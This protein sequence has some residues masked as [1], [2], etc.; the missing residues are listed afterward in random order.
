MT[1]K[2]SISGRPAFTPRT[3]TSTAFGE[4][5]AEFRQAP[6][7]LEIDVEMRKQDAA[8]HAEPDARDQPEAECDESEGEGAEGA[9]RQTR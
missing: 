5:V 3:I 6:L 7:A 9:R 4:L 8:G 2:Q 1:F